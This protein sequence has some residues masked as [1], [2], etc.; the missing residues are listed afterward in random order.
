LTGAGERI[1]RSVSITP[2]IVCSPRNFNTSTRFWFPTGS[3][4]QATH[5]R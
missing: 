4:F 1:A 2:L 3:A 5:P